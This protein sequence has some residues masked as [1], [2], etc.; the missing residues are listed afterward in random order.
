MEAARPNDESTLFRAYAVPFVLFLGFNLLLWAVEMHYKWDHPSAPWYQRMPELWVYAL[1]VAACGGYLAAMRRHVE[2][3][4]KLAPCLWGAAA[5]TV[6]IGLWLIPYFT[7]WIPAEGGFEPERIFGDN[8]TSLAAAYACRFA[9]AVVIV[10]FVEE[11]F[12]RGYLM[13]RCVN[14][15]F[16]HTVPLGQA[17]WLSYAVVTAAFMLVHRPCD[18][19]GALVYGTLTFLLVVKT[20]RLMPAVVMHAVAN[21]IMGLCAVTY[22]LPHLW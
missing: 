19:A 8:S 18:Y 10:P 11:L 2:W 5:G 13:R 22:N 9:R 15:D 7:G 6:G 20:R 12:W 3:D 1:Q 4:F 17:T 16:P 21:L 14:N